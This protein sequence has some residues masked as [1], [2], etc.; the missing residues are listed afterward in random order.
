MKIPGSSPQTKP[1]CGGALATLLPEPLCR[2]HPVEGRCLLFRAL[3]V[4]TALGSSLMLGNRGVRTT[5]PTRLS[6][7][8]LLCCQASAGT[9]SK[10]SG[11][12]FAA[13]FTIIRQ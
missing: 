8:Q 6:E 7:A 12:T 3:L 9:S 4:P 2:E 10:N 13:H 5:R 11:R 1:E